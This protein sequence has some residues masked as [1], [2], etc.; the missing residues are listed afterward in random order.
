MCHPSPAIV[1]SHTKNLTHLFHE[2][3]VHICTDGGPP[4]P[5]KFMP[6]H[7][8][9][10]LAAQQSPSS[11]AQEAMPLTYNPY[12]C[13]MSPVALQRR[14]RDGGATSPYDP[15][16]PTSARAGK[17]YDDVHRSESKFHRHFVPN[18]PHSQGIL[19]AQL[20]EF[21]PEGHKRLF[22]EEKLRTSTPPPARAQGSAPRAR[23]AGGANAPNAFRSSFEIFPVDVPLRG[24]SSSM[25]AQQRHEGVS[26]GPTA[27]YKKTL[28]RRVSR[29]GMRMGVGN[30]PQ[31]PSSIGYRVVTPYARDD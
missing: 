16:N 13:T 29:E 10:N 24:S 30:K 26:T 17:S 21:K 15:R 23:G 4:P 14:L 25:T 28:E 12:K 27:D 7:S 8:E 5:H 3:N 19:P 20:P 9:A 11:A 2:R 1:P 6:I 22:T 31:Q 18:T